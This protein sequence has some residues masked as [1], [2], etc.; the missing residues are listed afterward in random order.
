MGQVHVERCGPYFSIIELQR[1]TTWNLN[2]GLGR[3]PYKKIPGR[4]LSNAKFMAA[5]GSNALLILI[6]N[7][8][9]PSSRDEPAATV[10]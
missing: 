4:A 1:R 8:R 5:N 10:F 6:S 9:Q 3:D 2:E 7:D